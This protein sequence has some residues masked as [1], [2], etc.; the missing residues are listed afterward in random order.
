MHDE[1]H[2]CRCCKSCWNHVEEL[3]LTVVAIVHSVAVYRSGESEVRHLAV[4]VVVHEDV[5]S[6]Q[7]TMDQAKALD[8]LHSGGHLKVDRIKQTLH[9]TISWKTLYYLVELEF[10]KFNHTDVQTYLEPVI[11]ARCNFIIENQFNAEILYDYII[12]K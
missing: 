10:W 3:Q 11:S 5:S 6:R 12:C 2:S 7:V 1:S 4:L 9:Q 8:V